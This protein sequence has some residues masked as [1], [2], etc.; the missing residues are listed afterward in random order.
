MVSSEIE[1]IAELDRSEH[2]TREYLHRGDSLELRAVD[3]RVPPWS[4]ASDHSHSVR[5]KVK[6]WKPIVERG[7]V[8]VGAFDGQTLAGIA[9]FEAD[10]E[11]GM[12]NFA[13]LH[14]SRSYRSQGIG[15]LLAEEVIRL[16]RASDASRLYVSATPTA[17]TVEFY[18]GL[19]FELAPQPH[20]EMFRA[21]P[22]DIHM[23][24]D[25]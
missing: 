2:I 21:E 9:I 5:A 10:L 8:L 6:A 1:R 13:V 14:V 15:A 17:P 7:G 12:A 25:L 18:Q 20:A 4:S 3:I 23:I 19:G 11:P 22:Y 24:L 16:A